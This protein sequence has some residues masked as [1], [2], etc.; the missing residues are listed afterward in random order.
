MKNKIKIAGLSLIALLGL[1]ACSE[2][3]AKPTTYNEKLVTFPEGTQEIYNNAA[4]VVYDAIHDGG[5]GKDVLKTVLYLYSVTAFGAYDRTVEVGG[6]TVKLGEVTLTEAVNSEREMATFIKTHKTYWDEGKTEEHEPTTSEIQRV[7]AKLKSINDRIAEKMYDKISGGSYSDRHIF[8]EAEFL[9]S[10]RN[11][12]ESVANPLD[13]GVALYSGPILPSVEPEDVFGNYLHLENYYSSDNKYIIDK[14]IP[15]IYEELL[16]ELYLNQETYNTLGRSYARKVNI[17]K[18]ENNEDYPNAAFYLASQL[19]KE[20]NTTDPIEAEAIRNMDIL[21][22]F[23]AYSR[24]YIGYDLSSDEQAILENSGGFI[25]HIANNNNNNNDDVGTYYEGTKYGDIASKYLKMVNSKFVETDIENSFTSNNTY[26]TYIG[27][28]QQSIALEEKDYT[29]NGWFI[30][31]GGLNE[32]P[33]E[34]R[35]R[36]FNIS[37]ANGINEKDRDANARTYVDGKWVIPSTENGFL[38]RV[39]GHNY[40]KK[41]NRIAGEGVENDILFY[42]TSSKAYYIVEVV[43]AASSSKLSLTGDNNYAKTRGEDVMEDFINRIGKL[44]GADSSYS[45][46]AKKKYL[47]EMNIVYYD[48]SVY[49]YFKSNYPELF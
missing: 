44:V 10:L 14:I 38:C 45:T 25:P 26:P 1:S 43:E 13:P 24:A 9:K 46:L 8:S 48:D 15:D 35:D 22:K 20:L 31:N 40:L 39:N 29:T 17:I 27:L 11:A 41:E 23:K 32:L 12:M 36:L 42:D 5:I 4:N 49:N 19:V 37:V 47:K 6:V 18:F 33:S 21:N 7:K 16:N 28:L 30:K 3:I 34:I 2:V